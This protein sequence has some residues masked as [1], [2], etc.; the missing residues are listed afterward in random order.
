MPSCPYKCT[1]KVSHVVPDSAPDDCGQ[2]TTRPAADS[3]QGQRCLTA[4]GDERILIREAS[5]H[6]HHGRSTRHGSGPKMLMAARSLDESWA[7]SQLMVCSAAALQERAS[8][9]IP[10]VL[11]VARHP[12]TPGPGAGPRAAD[13]LHAYSPHETA[14]TSPERPERVFSLLWGDWVVQ[15]HSSPGWPCCADAPHRPPGSRIRPRQAPRR[16]P[17]PPQLKRFRRSR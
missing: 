14:W 2:V 7:R 13:E 11:P 6:A 4:D 1:A 9:P 10:I 8:W 3:T 12:Q 17:R 5:P 16:H 15:R